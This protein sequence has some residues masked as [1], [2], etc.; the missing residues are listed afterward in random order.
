MK[1]FIRPACFTVLMVAAGAMSYHYLGDQPETG[2]APDPA[3][4][5]WSPPQPFTLKLADPEAVWKTRGPWG[6]PPR[7]APVPPPPPPPP[8]VPVPVGIVA[9]R[10]GLEAL[11]VVP[12]A[13]EMRLKVGGKLP[14]GGRVTAISAFQIR[15]T[16]GKGNKHERELFGGPLPTL[17]PG[18]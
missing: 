5:S 12:G 7:P 9:S 15:W 17:P 10:T 4:E 16:D 1:A 18:V 14:D 11:F 2:A 8:P 13:G 3:G 6:L